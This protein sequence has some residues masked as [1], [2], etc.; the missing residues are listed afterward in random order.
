L[1]SQKLDLKERENLILSI[2]TS[3]DVTM[4]A[5]WLLG[6][7]GLLAHKLVVWLLEHYRMILSVW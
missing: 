3:Y 5:Y 2:F 6:L 4:D 1:V 7:L